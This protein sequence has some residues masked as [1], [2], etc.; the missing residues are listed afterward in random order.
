MARD[1]D[2]GWGSGSEGMSDGKRSVRKSRRGGEKKRQKQKGR[3]REDERGRR[4]GKKGNRCKY[5][6][7]QTQNIH[8]PPQNLLLPAPSA[9][10]HC[11]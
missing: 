6:V 7:G 4:R 8:P 11:L 1:K 5:Q 3:K 10:R 9:S 2:R